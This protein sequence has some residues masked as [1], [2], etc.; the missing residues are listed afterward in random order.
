MSMVE[1]SLYGAVLVFFLG[2]SYRVACWFR[3]AVGPDAESIGPRARVVAAL[4]G[5]AGVLFGKKLFTLVRSLLFDVIFQARV[6]R[7]DRFRWI[8]HMCMFSG[9][10]LLLF[11]HALDGFITG[12]LFEEYQPTVNPY[13]FLRNL[14]AFLVLLGVALAVLRRCFMKPPRLRS[15]TMDAFSLILLGAV[16]LSGVMLEATKITSYSRYRSMVEDFAY[17]ED[18]DAAQS[19]EAF[20][21]ENYGVVA[22]ETPDRKKPFDKETLDQGR[23][24][25]EINCAACHSRPAW[26]FLGYAVSRAAKPAALSLDRASASAFFWHIHFLACVIGLAYLPFSKM[27]HIFTVPLS[28]LAGTVMDE[29]SDPANIA[30]RQ[31]MELDACTHCGACTIACAVGVC[32]ES[33]GNPTILPS[34]K[35]APIKAFVSGRMQGDGPLRTIQEGLAI[36]TNCRVCT[37]ICPSGINLQDL[38]VNVREK[39]LRTYRPPV[40]M[41]SP[42]SFYRGLQTG[43]TNGDQQNRYRE[44]LEKARKTIDK[45][46]PRIQKPGEPIEFSKADRTTKTGLLRSVQGSSFTYCF[47]CTTCTSACPVVHSFQNRSEALDFTPHQIVRAVN[48]GITDQ[49]FGSKMLWSCLGCYQCQEHCP[50]GVRVTDIFY[51]LKNMAMSRMRGTEPAPWIHRSEP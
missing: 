1:M 44:S 38:W 49:V 18:A 50:Q 3:R 19:L 23:E 11:M 21:V 47:T 20:W 41:L 24:W 32:I 40:Q 10:L 8:M 2:F 46:F 14:G 45:A 34:E 9:F 5:T 48:L 39:L 30:T 25:H 29:K 15:N 27:F 6:F 26:A 13:L 31:V 28:L 35:I 51:E 37:E 17:L 7:R 12:P 16:V 43:S 36:C 4:K 33:M 42:L 22:P